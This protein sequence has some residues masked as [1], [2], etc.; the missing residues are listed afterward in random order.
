MQGALDLFSGEVKGR[1]CFKR[2]ETALK[3]KKKKRL[4]TIPFRR[5][6]EPACLGSPS[7]TDIDLKLPHLFLPKAL[8]SCL[9]GDTAFLL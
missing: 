4:E 9:V 1:N 2:L 7:Q 8:G 3:V 6:W 5:A